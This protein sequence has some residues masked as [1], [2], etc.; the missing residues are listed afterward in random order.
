[1]RASK[2]LALQVLSERTK[3]PH[4][5]GGPLDGWNLSLED[6]T[7]FAARHRAIQNGAMGTPTLP[8][9]FREMA[10]GQKRRS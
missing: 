4:D 5:C 8:S 3:G 2:N 7:L 1:V 6:L 9:P 10:I